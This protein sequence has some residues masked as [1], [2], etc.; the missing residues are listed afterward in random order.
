MY[1]D[2]NLVTCCFLVY[3]WGKEVLLQV[4]R[5]NLIIKCSVLL[6]N[7]IQATLNFSRIHIKINSFVLRSKVRDNIK[8]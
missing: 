7:F 8:N 6:V 4:R 3:D 2:Q 5:F 1:Y